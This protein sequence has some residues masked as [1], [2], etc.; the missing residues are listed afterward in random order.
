MRIKFLMPLML[1]LLLVGSESVV[2]NTKGK[3]PLRDP[4]AIGTREVD[5][6]LN[7]YSLEKE[8]ELGRQLAQEV[9]KKAKIV[10]DPVVSEYV[11]RVAQ[12][13]ARHSDVKVPVT[14]KVIDDDEVN[15]FALPGG[16]LFVNTGLIR[17][18]GSE[19][20]LA[21]VI[22]HELAH[23]AARHGTRQASRGQV[24][25]WAT[26]PLIFMGGW[27]GYGIQ[28]AAN[29]GIPLTFL[30]FSRDFERE[31]DLLAVQ[32]LYAAGYDPV[33]YVDF[34]EKIQALEK[35]RPGALSELIRSHPSTDDR[36]REAQRNIQEILPPRPDYVV[37]TSEFA[38][39]HE[40]LEKL[41]AMRKPAAGDPNKPTLRR[42]PGS[43]RPVEPIGGKT[44]D[45]DDRPTLKRGS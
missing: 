45:S 37:T 10:D 12:N 6:G 40:R 43:D 9:E 28:Q 14:A 20:E 36:I 41:M 19:A 23:V 39:V 26:L 2:A 21:G 24:A 1:S 18:A 15:A 27:A 3:D 13:I 31:A 16:Y 29:F 5:K 32:Y 22:A 38:Q 44:E 17:R 34:L 30:K 7:L 42:A 33:A 35:T 4:S 25:S 8:I 11:N